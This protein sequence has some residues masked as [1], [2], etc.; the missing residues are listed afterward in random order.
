MKREIYLI[1]F[2]M[3]LLFS[4]NFV[5]SEALLDKDS[6]KIV[7][8]NYFYMQGCS[9]CAQMRPFLEEMQ[10]NYNITLNI[11]E[12][13]SRESSSLFN[14]YLE[15]Y[16]VPNEQR[17]YVPTVF[18]DNNYFI[19]FSKEI[20]NSIEN[21]IIGES[22]NID[23]TFGGEIVKSKIL[24]LWNVE[25]SLKNKSL[26][27][28]TLLLGFLD[29][30]NIC[31]ITV[32]IFLIV[33][34]MSIGSLK[35]A[36]KLGLIFTSIVYIFYFLFMFALTSIIGSLISQYGV[37]IRIILVILSFITGALLIKD[38][39][40]YGK[41]ISLKI[42]SSTK[43]LLEKYLKKATVVSTIMFA[44]LASLVEIPCTAIFPLI[45]STILAENMVIGISR[46]FWIAVYNIIYVLPL[47]IIVFGTYF[48]WT[49]INDIDNQIQKYKKI[50]KLI[51][52]LAL[53]GISIYF[54]IPFLI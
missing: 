12:I 40:F 54:F 25:I 14:D 11:Y 35:R 3:L 44:L 22:N 20:T 19:G 4:F 8:I 10:D 48:S 18:I 15:N 9:A 43:P 7:E 45:Y 5:S 28:T 42:P 16:D 52:G 53:I 32:L 47:L 38:Y 36:F 17:G 39:F 34:T 1:T 24:G 29:S 51:A 27:T 13:S 33:Y 2:C 49:K 50:M 26:I 46:F 31:S 37:Y 23:S 21:I 30:L 41:G 6:S